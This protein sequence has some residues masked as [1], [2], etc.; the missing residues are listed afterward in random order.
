MIDDTPLIQASGSKLAAAVE[1]NLIAFFHAMV[2]VLPE[3]QIV[4]KDM[5]SYHITFPSNPMFKGVWRAQLS[6]DEADEVISET[7]AWF[8]AQ[9]APY[10]FWWTGQETTPESL[11]ARLQARGLLDM[12]EQQ[13]ELA[14]GI[15][16]TERGAPG[17]A[18]DLHQ[19]NESLVAKVPSGFQIKAVENEIELYEFKKVFVETYEIPE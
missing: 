13:R 9:G 14:S 4:E 3:G 15:R 1:E 8:T 2:K 10:F 5:I 19:V 17:M 12:A 18:A 11:G 16:Q 7:I 6:E